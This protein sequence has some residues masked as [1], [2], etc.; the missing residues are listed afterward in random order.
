[1][2]VRDTLFGPNADSAGP[3]PPF[4]LMIIGILIGIVGVPSLLFVFGIGSSRVGPGY[5]DLH[6]LIAASS[7]LLL[8]GIACGL[9]MFGRELPS[10]KETSI[11][12][13]DGDRGV[14]KRGEYES[15]T[16]L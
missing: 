13:H 16:G 5:P 10:P 9:F 2:F 12:H 11:H 7:F 15:R 6:W 8:A 4:L 3:L 1:M 14:R